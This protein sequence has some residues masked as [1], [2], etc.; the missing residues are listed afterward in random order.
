MLDG[1][2]VD[3][4]GGDAVPL[5]SGTTLKLL[6]TY[7]GIDQKTLAEQCGLKPAEISRY[8]T[9]ERQIPNK[10]RLGI[11]KILHITPLGWG[12]MEDAV[13]QLERDQERFRRRWGHES[14]V[15]GI[16]VPPSEIRERF[17][18]GFPSLDPEVADSLVSGVTRLVESGLHRVVGLFV[19][20]E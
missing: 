13:V 18:T 3:P 1:N 8:V 6:L 17:G 10:Q 12:I 20:R 7:R 5:P 14:E 19:A 11:L 16:Q 2:R 4:E 15:S 9:G